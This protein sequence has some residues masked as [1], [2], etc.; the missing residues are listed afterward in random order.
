MSDEQVPSSKSNDKSE[1]CFA[2]PVVPKIPFKKP[3]L[4]KKP[5]TTTDE[6]VTESSDN[7]QP[8]PVPESVKKEF[9]PPLTN[10]Q[11][12][13]DLFYVEII[14]DGTIVNKHYLNKNCIIIGR[15]TDCDLVFEH[16][17]ISRYHAALY[18]K[19]NSQ[20]ADD[21][22]FFYLTDLCSSHGTIVNKSQLEQNKFLKLE[23]NK[24]FIKLGV[25]SRLLLFSCTGLD[26]DDED[27][28]QTNYMANSSMPKQQAQSNDYECMWGMDMDYDSARDLYSQSDSGLQIVLTIINENQ[29]ID[30]TEN[31]NAYSQNPQ[32][33]IQNWFDYEGYEY[34]YT[35]AN[36]HNKFK[37]IIEF[38]LEDQ[39][40]PISGEEE[41]KVS[42]ALNFELYLL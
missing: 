33:A 42:L 21:N 2:I 3:D 8:S 10:L 27:D 34:E 28:N 26:D 19:E 11:P 39:H 23:P 18:W 15:A 25:S 29:V 6:K 9:P 41:I 12:T 31:E 37:C 30:K 36:E 24:S 5:T 7:C 32:K 20:N 4:I 13:K 22:G 40:V 17:S 35:I 1:N 38:P 16:C 14:K